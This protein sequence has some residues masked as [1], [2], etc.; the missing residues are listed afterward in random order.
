MFNLMFLIILMYV[1]LSIKSDNVI[2]I[3]LLYAQDQAFT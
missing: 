1:I 2:E 3:L